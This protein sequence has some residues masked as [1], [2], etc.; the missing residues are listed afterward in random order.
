MINL[1]LSSIS[2]FDGF[3][4]NLQQG[5]FI[6]KVDEDSPAEWAHLK[7]NDVIIEVNGVPISNENHKQVVS[8]IKAV[9]NETHLLVIDKREYAWYEQ[10]KLIIRASQA[11]VVHYKTPV[12]RPAN[13]IRDDDPPTMNG[14]ND[15]NAPELA[16]TSTASTPT[17][18]KESNNVSS[19]ASTPNTSLE[20]RNDHH[21]PKSIDRQTDSPLAD[22][23]LKEL[24]SKENHVDEVA[25]KLKSTKLQV[26]I[27]DLFW[28]VF[29]CSCWISCV[30]VACKANAFLNL[31]VSVSI[32]DR[33]PIVF[34]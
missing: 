14:E 22:E 6:G 17:H 18:S 2:D 32:I 1:P 3:G 30:C 31:K 28:V 29:D 23:I 21:S 34:N 10:R 16:N 15:E 7:E 25:N 13:P 5:H 20:H 26:R 27:L 11:N 24:A 33:L 9:P 19:N 4:F 8:R 12:P